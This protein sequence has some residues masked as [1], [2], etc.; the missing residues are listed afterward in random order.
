MTI[1]ISIYPEKT[2]QEKDKA[3]IDLAYSLGFRRVFTSL[4][5][6]TGDAEQVIKNFKET[7][8]YASN[9]GMEVMVDINPQIFNQIGVSYEDLSFFAKLGAYGI[10]LDMGFTGR[11]E[12]EM[13]RNP[14]GLKI[15]VNMSIGTKYIDNL[16]SFS[17]NRKNLIGS[18]NFYPMEYSGLD[19]GFYKH[20]CQQ[21]KSYNLQTAAFI[22]SKNAD[23]GP[24][25][26]QDGLCTLEQHRNK[27]IKTQTQYY[28]LDD[29]IDTIIVGDAYASVEE[30]TEISEIYFATHPQLQVVL[31]EDIQ[32]VER[33][34]VLEEKHSYRGDQSS[35]L[36]RS[37]LPRFKYK[38]ESIVARECF[39]LKRGDIVVGNNN[40]GQ[41][42]AE[43]HIVLQDIPNNKQR[44]NL[45]GR[46]TEESIELLPKLKPWSKFKLIQ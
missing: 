40:F 29:A 12:A 36:I 34:I 7:V 32:P 21:F 45:V 23:M 9:L 18:H 22:T 20:C 27:S 16:M 1:G 17:P 3:Y 44:C 2:T 39:A 46:L 19:E 43:L 33:K 31:A 26:L 6:L 41:Y 24:W 4:L 38:K 14:Y 11:E 13:T 28:L 10:R 15:E 37:S 35:F 30:L 8:Q 5:E 42:K 25:P